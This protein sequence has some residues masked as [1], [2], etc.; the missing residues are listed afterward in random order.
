M[1]G[2]ATDILGVLALGLQPGMRGGREVPCERFV[3]IGASL[4]PDKRRPGNARGSHDWLG[5]RAARD[6]N[7]R[8]RC[9][10]AGAG[11]QI[12]APGTNPSCQGKAL[13]AKGGLLFS[14]RM[15]IAVLAKG[16]EA[17]R[18]TT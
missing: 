7:H 18:Q 17:M 14:H 15:Y 2:F 5:K 13:R 4:G 16:A 9:T 6:Q 12:E 3:A 8:E 11:D 1:A 10:E